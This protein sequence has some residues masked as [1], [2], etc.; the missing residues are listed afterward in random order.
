[1]AYEITSADVKVG[2][3]T[4]AMVAAIGALTFATATPRPPEQPKP[5]DPA[6]IAKCEHTILPGLCI[7]VDGYGFPDPKPEPSPAP[8]PSASSLPK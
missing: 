1:M 8:S 2:M 5:V 3:L 6:I 7:Y 4:F